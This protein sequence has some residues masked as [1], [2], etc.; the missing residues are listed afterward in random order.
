MKGEH[1]VKEFIKKLLVWVLNKLPLG[2]II[3][4]EAFPVFEDNTGALYRHMLREHWNDEWKLVW[5]ARKKEEYHDPPKVKNVVYLA[6]D[7]KKDAVRLFFYRCR[8]A[9]IIDC[10]TQLPKLNPNTFHFYLTHGSLIKSVKNYQ[11]CDSTTDQL[12]DQASFFTQANIE[13]LH[14]PLWKLVQLGFP[15]NDELWLGKHITLS[16]KLGSKC[17]RIVV[18][19]PTYRQMKAS[20]RRVSNISIPIIHSVEAAKIVN[21]IAERWNVLILVKPHPAQ[22]LSFIQN[23][24]LS[25]LRFI[26]NQFVENMGL[27]LYEF[28]GATDALITDYS[29]VFYDYLLTKKMVALTFE[30]EDQYAQNPGFAVDTTVLKEAAYLLEKPEDFDDLFKYVVTGEDP[31]KEKRLQLMKTTNRYTDNKSAKRVARFI[32]DRLS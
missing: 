20:D 26:D 6:R 18:W 7:K 4:L 15:R 29:S 1:K 22:D 32:M 30:D 28:L 10:N 27:L 14:V 23:L 25:N 11:L 19:Y 24:Q 13:N 9:A 12:L 17:N 8:A 21:E 31:L 5:L 2:R 3:I 16:E